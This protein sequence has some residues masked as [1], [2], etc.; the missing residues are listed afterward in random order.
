MARYWSKIEPAEIGDADRGKLLYWYLHAAL[1]GRHSG[2]T[3]SMLNQDLDAVERGGLDG[4]IQLLRLSRGDLTVRS[5]NLSGAY[6]GSRFYPLIYM[7]SRVHGARDLATGNPVSSHLLGKLSRLELHHI[8]PK[9]L[10]QEHGYD[11]AERN[12]LA[13]FCFITQ[14]TNL[15]IGRRD[16]AEYLPKYESLNPGVLASQWIPSDPELWKPARYQD[17]LAARRTLLAAA[18]NDFLDGLVAGA[19]APSAVV[20]KRPTGERQVAEDPEVLALA[21][22]A[23]EAVTLGLAEPEVDHEVTDGETGEV[24][25]WADLAWPDGVRV[26]LT[27]PVAYLAERDDELERRFGELGWRFYTDE[28]GLRRYFEEVLGVDLDGDGIIGQVPDEEVEPS[29]RASA[30]GASTFTEFL[31]GIDGSLDA[32]RQELTQLSY[33]TDPRNRPDDSRRARFRAGW[34][35]AADGQAYTAEVLR[36]LTWDNLGWRLGDRYGG[37]EPDLID[38][39]FDRFADLWH[40]D[41]A[42]GGHAGPSGA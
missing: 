24:L 12:A 34:L 26:G 13:N 32:C 22:L 14:E 38:R 33:T 37:Q 42:D 23:K 31:T 7:L 39:V 16:P 36:R 2:S 30:R 20:L 4:L 3:E 41:H 17:F 27:D 5:E 35:K 18:A 28:A 1:W 6:R 25:A 8:F 21:A 9:A 19:A 11:R 40:A 10:L 29:S 15:A